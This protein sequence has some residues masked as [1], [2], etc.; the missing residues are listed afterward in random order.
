MDKAVSEQIQK[1][2]RNIEQVVFGKHD[3]V[4]MCVTGLL[5]RGH[6]LIE[7][8]PGIGKT[9]IAQSIARSMDCSFSRIQFTSDMLPSDII[10]VSILNQHTN[11]FEFRKGP[12]FAHV[13]LAD[14][15]NRTPPKTQS[16]L[17]EAMSEYQVTVDGVAHPLPAPFI[18]LATQNPIE[19]EGT[20]VLP[21]SQLDRFTMR[22]EVGY[23]PAEDEMRIIRRRDPLK[24][25]HDL[26][27]VLN[28][29]ELVALQDRVGEVL[30][31][32]SV[33]EYLLA[34]VRA[35]R[36][37]EQVQLGASPRGALAFYEACQA[38]ALVE[39]RDYVTPGDVKQMAAPVLSHRL[40]IKTRGADLSMAARERVRVVHDIIKSI[41]VPL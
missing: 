3:V 11:E 17:L 1:F 10:G 15:V 35:T 22:V 28:T 14:E 39:G 40:L 2:I 37:H 7:D 21:E 12:V 5:A 19:Y 4:K 27:P 41:E 20:Y 31:D 23:P 8:V 16:A 13:L 33:A 30:V 34:I 25:I 38:F 32:E 36:E 29:A 24:A 9:T 26:Q 18:V 6:I